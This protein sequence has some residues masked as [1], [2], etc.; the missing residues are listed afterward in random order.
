MFIYILYMY[1]YIY[2]YIQLFLDHIICGDPKGNLMFRTDPSEGS[3]DQ[4]AEMACTRCGASWPFATLG[5]DAERNE[6]Q[7]QWS[8][9]V[10]STKAVLLASRYSMGFQALYATKTLRACDNSTTWMP[11]TRPCEHG[12]KRC[13]TA[14]SCTLSTGVVCF[15]IIGKKKLPSHELD[16]MIDFVNS[17][18]FST[19]CTTRTHK[20][21]IYIYRDKCICKYIYIHM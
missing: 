13:N 9:I 2:I 16:A 8:S 4:E 14:T 15:P 17:E 6:V 19:A 21:I 11:S 10:G 18:L 3:K 7:Q 5:S 20:H 12:S 1:L